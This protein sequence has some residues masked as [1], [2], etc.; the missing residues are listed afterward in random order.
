MMIPPTPKA[1]IRRTALW[2]RMLRN[3][4]G[5][6]KAGSRIIMKIIMAKIT[7]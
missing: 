3:T 4:K 1:N 7:M 5:D 2:V 6:R